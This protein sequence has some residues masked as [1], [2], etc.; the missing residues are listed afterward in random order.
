MC[1]DACHKVVDCTDHTGIPQCIFDICGACNTSYVRTT[2]WLP[3][4]EIS[5]SPLGGAIHAL[6]YPG[7]TK[8]RDILNGLLERVIATPDIDTPD[9]VSDNETDTSPPGSGSRPS[10][11]GPGNRPPRPGT[12]GQRPRGPGGDRTRPSRGV[13]SPEDKALRRAVAWFQKGAT[14]LL[15]RLLESLPAFA[16]GRVGPLPD[17]LLPGGS[18]PGRRDSG[19]AATN[20]TVDR[21]LTCKGRPLYIYAVSYR[22]II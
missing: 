14:L 4:L 17:R 20:R 21:H 1:R 3:N 18:R 15:Q 7:E 9:I 6:S 5:R 22:S 16:R 19:T 12:R 13:P 8:L 11:P 2:R 10:Q